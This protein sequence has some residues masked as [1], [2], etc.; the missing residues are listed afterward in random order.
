MPFDTS[1]F[2]FSECGKFQ[3]KTLRWKTILAARR[4]REKC[5]PSSLMG[6]EKSWVSVSSLVRKTSGGVLC[7]LSCS[8]GNSTWFLLLA[9]GEMPGEGG[10]S[11]KD[12]EFWPQQLIK[13]GSWAQVECKAR[14]NY[15]W[16]LL[17]V[18]LIILHII[19]EWR[20]WMTNKIMFNPIMKFLTQ[21]NI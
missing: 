19:H 8:Q 12:V 5:E 15:F 3:R 16:T 13:W 14:I 7:S 1:W 10:G 6:E 17:S 18:C 20:H 9:V 21:R 2:D 4:K 11:I